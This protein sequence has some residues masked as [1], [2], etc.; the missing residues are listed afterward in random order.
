M[1]LPFATRNAGK[2]RELAAL[3]APHGVE[4]V[5]DPRGYPE[6]QADTLEEVARF[7]AAHLRQ[8]GLAPPFALED[9][10]LFVAAL[11]GFPGVYSRHALDTLGCGGLL[12]LMRD[13]EA[14]SRQAS[15]QAV[16]AYVDPAGEL[17][18]FRGTCRGRIAERAAGSGGFGFDPLFVPEGGERTFAQM[19]PGEKDRRS[20]RAEAARA[21]AAFLGKTAK[22]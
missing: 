11:K 3:L 4:V 22:R 1:R 7:G 19:P 13:V 6:V 21:L 18:L 12:R 16:L 9:S 17:H 8:A 10:G 2:A 14:E 15:F 20:H 5:Q